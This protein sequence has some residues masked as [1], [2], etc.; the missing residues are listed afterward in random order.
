MISCNREN[1][2]R[3]RLIGTA[4]KKKIIETV[5]GNRFLTAEDLYSD[6]NLNHNN[7]SVHTIRRIPNDKRL[8][9]YKP[10]IIP[11]VS[12]VKKEKRMEFCSMTSRWTK[13]WKRIL[14]KNESWPCA[15]PYRLHHVHRCSFEKNA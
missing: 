7:V 4:T 5:F 8:R 13:K 11:L 2:G 14:F 9:A 15:K 3:E 10:K 6:K 12:E 1:C